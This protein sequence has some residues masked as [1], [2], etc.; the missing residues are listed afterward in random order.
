GS[1]MYRSGDLTRYRADGKLE[2]LGRIDDQV[3]LRGYR[4]ELGEVEAALRS[5]PGVRQAAA[6]VH[7]GTGGERRLIAYVVGA[8]GSA[9]DET[10]LRAH[11]GRVLPQYMLP[12]QYVGLSELPL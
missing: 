11:L 2:Y 5:H 3:K 8:E 12:G 4:I 10:Q 9:P 6:A 1:R 7:E